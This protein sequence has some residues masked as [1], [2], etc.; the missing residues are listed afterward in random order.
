MFIIIYKIEIM[1]VYSSP[2]ITVLMAIY[3]CAP[4]LVEALDS[5]MG[6][7]YQRFKVVLCDDCSTD[8]TYEV[9]RKYIEQ[10][11][12]KFILIRNDTN[13]KL[14]YSLNRCLEYADTE[15]V[16][17][18]DGDDISKPERFEKEITFLDRHKEYV[19]VST[20]MEYFDENGIFKVGHPV[21]RPSKENFIGSTPHAHAPAMI[22]TSVILSVGGYTDERWTRRGQDVHLWAKIYSKG[23]RGYNLTEP[24][25]MMRDDISAYKR[26]RVK[27]AVFAV[28]RNYEIYRLMNISY[29]NVYGLIRPLLVALLP[30]FIY[31][32]VH[33]Q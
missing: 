13:R 9:A 1:S 12:D 3:N 20:A 10:F 21:E 15:Y 5:L 2:R 30:K 7:T 14:P 24:L 31:D 25:Y 23:Y 26:R 33:K 27:E 19:I 22:R 32:K 29:L 18:M 16:A 11:P 28:R 17:R 4:T 8:N 6:Q